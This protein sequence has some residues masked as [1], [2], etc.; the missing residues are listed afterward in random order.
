[1]HDFANDPSYVEWLQGR[2]DNNELRHEFVQYT[3]A[4]LKE[5]GTIREES[6]KFYPTRK[7]N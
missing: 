7:D 4:K 1:M 3:L 6:G 5:S 2:K